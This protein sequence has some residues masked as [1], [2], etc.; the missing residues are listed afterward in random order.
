MIVLLWSE[1]GQDLKN[2]VKDTW[3]RC[4]L[5]EERR[6]DILVVI[7][8]TALEEALDTLRGD[9][10]FQ[11]KGV[12]CAAP[13]EASDTLHG[14]VKFWRN[15]VLCKEGGNNLIMRKTLRFSV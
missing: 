12:S 11:R 3:R 14:D 15:Y 9:V 13:E 1:G 8:S 2:G 6:L 10:D 7:I 4:R 5:S